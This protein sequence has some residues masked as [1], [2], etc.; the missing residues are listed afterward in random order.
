MFI[1]KITEGKFCILLRKYHD[2]T[3]SLNDTALLC[4]Y[5]V[6]KKVLIKFTLRVFFAWRSSYKY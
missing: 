2:A 5:I 6:E 3:L 1:Y 4:I